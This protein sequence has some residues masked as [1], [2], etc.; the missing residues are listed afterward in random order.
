MA[1][2]RTRGAARMRDLA[3]RKYTNLRLSVNIVK[4]SILRDT[5]VEY[6]L[7]TL[8]AVLFPRN[9]SP[10]LKGHTRINRPC[11]IHSIPALEIIIL[12]LH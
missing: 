6:V 11:H 2:D 10:S 4:I 7:Y 8:H 1:K 12:T 3:E 5:N 9:S